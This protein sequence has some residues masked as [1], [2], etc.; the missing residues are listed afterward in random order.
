MS[1][2]CFHVQRLLGK[3]ARLERHNADTS[4]QLQAERRKSR[5][6]A[7]AVELLKQQ[8]GSLCCTSVAAADD[9]ADLLFNQLVDDA[10]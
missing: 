3:I 9:V 4:A 10:R 2:C 1:W 8:V 7:E 5:T 6:L